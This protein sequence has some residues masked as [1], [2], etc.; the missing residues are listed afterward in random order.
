M[1]GWC[2]RLRIKGAASNEIEIAHVDG[3]GNVLWMALYLTAIIPTISQEWW[4]GARRYLGGY[5]RGARG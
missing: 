2:A 4:Q 5:G 3:G 1:G